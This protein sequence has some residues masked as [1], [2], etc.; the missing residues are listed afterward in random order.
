[1]CAQIQQLSSYFGWKLRAQF[2]E[3]SGGLISRACGGACVL[4]VA[5]CSFIE[6][7]FGMSFE[8]GAVDLK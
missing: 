1:M 3:V 7:I 4:M 8:E 6:D 5:W 2:Q